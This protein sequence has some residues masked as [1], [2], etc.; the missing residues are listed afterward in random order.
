MKTYFF[1]GKIH[2]CFILSYFCNRGGMM[3]KIV[4]VCISIVLIL[5]SDFVKADTDLAPNAKSAILIEASTGKIIFE[6]NSHEKLAP[7]SM[8]KMMSMLIIVESVEKGIIGWDDMVTAS[9]NASKMGGS[10][11]LLETGE[12]MSVS[13]LFKGVA[14]AS[15][16]DAVIALAEA[17]AGTE[18]EFV[19]MM[20][21]RAKEL[22]LTDTI[23]KNPHGLDDANHY[24]S[25]HDMML[26]AKELVKHE[27][28][29]EYTSIYEDYLRKGTPKELW[30][31]NTN[32]LT[33]FY[34][35]VDGLKTGFTDTAGYCL[36]A[37]AKKN[38]M[39]L[40]AVVMGEADSKV[41]NAEVTSMLDYGFA[42]YKVNELLNKDTIISKVEIEKGKSKQ[43][44]LVPLREAI[45]VTKKT[46]TIGK[47]TYDLHLNSVK[48]PIQI[49]DKVG[50]LD[51]LENDNKI[52][53]VDVTVKENVKKASFAD[54]FLRYFGDM[55]SG[56]IQF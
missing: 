38:G 14:V 30:L 55:L 19:S 39:R 35:G 10:Q 9:E 17:V 40:I 12:Q 51:I 47:I 36:T 13:D 3:K 45:I 54:L 8:T 41:R 27:K 23:F 22:G 56:A 46:E 25:A 33:R 34:P 4:M 28:V 21:A 7:A 18:E 48:A 2:K 24:S 50:T 53:Q 6:K 11:I 42:Q 43:V 29:L 16:N 44:E 31:V 26:I 5:S 37:T 15:G 1:W 32:K 20:N 49:G 52:G